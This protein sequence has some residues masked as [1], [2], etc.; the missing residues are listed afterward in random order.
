MSTP[1]PVK[2]F[3]KFG[4]IIA[5]LGSVLVAVAFCFWS[6]LPQKKQLWRI[7][8]RERYVGIVLGVICLIWSASHAHALL[9]G[10]SA[11][12]RVFLG[13][14]VIL[15]TLLCYFLLDYLFT[16]ALGGILLLLVNWLLHEAFIENIQFRP[17]FSIICY[18]LGIASF[19]LIAAPYRFRDW[20]EKISHDNRWRTVSTGVM[21]FI[22][23]LLVLISASN[24]VL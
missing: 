20:L 14:G 19:F 5:L 12:F 2:T 4:I 13:P 23:G 15:V 7:I 9:E 18:L 10:A 3:M 16:R 1:T 8:P 22:G 21:A 11:K 24:Y 17:V 6:I